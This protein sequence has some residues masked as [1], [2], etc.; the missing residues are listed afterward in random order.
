MAI[1]VD[2]SIVD[3]E[4]VAPAMLVSLDILVHYSRV[5]GADRPYS[6]RGELGFVAVAN[7][8]SRPD[9]EVRSGPEAFV[10]LARY[11]VLYLLTIDSGPR[12]AIIHCCFERFDVAPRP[13]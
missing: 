4:S 7:A 9:A 12:A 6:K 8:D 3:R 1:T 11:A 10:R 13:D 2:C 5:R